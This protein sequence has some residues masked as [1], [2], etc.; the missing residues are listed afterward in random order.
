MHS[1]ILIIQ[2]FLSVT[3]VRNGR[4]KRKIGCFLFFSKKGSG[5]K[6]DDTSNETTFFARKI[7]QKQRRMRKKQKKGAELMPMN[8]QDIL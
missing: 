8:T 7:V 3:S 1:Y 4:M 2:L 5:K 6:R